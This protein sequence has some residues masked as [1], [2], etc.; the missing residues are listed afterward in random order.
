MLEQRDI[1]IEQFDKTLPGIR[2]ATSA[3]GETDYFM[4]QKPM[5]PTVVLLSVEYGAPLVQ[6]LHEI[7]SKAKCM[8]AYTKLLEHYSLEN[9]TDA[10]IMQNHEFTKRRVAEHTQIF[11]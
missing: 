7:G 6:T 11:Y 2:V 3:D 5:T 9:F 4:C 8:K 10:V 1:Y